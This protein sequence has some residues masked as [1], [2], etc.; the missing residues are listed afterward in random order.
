MGLNIAN[1]HYID[2][3]LSFGKPDDSDWDDPD[4][5]GDK[6]ESKDQT[7]ARIVIVEDELLV[8]E[9][10]KESLL[11]KGY[12]VVG[13]FS[14]GEEAIMEFPAL[15]PDLILMDIRLSGTLD[16][17]ETATIIYR[18]LKRV[19]IL[20]LTAYGEELVP[21]IES[22]SLAYELLTK[23][24]DKAR[25]IESIAKLLKRSGPLSN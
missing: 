19:P 8:A 11:A 5:A 25:M 24:Y 23:P 2:R 3:R 12:N 7:S 22:M 18:S 13:I 17:I 21:G 20:F 4:M 10:I 9:N 15:N 6:V 16:G 14:S 1:L